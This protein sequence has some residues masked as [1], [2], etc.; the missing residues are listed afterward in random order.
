MPF[1]LYNTK[2]FWRPENHFF[3]IQIIYL[4]LH[5]NTH[6]S[7]NFAAPWT[8]LPGGRQH[9]FLYPSPPLQVTPLLVL[10]ND[11]Q[12]IWQQ[13]EVTSYYMEGTN[14]HGPLLE[15]Y[16]TAEWTR[17][18]LLPHKPHCWHWLHN[19]VYGKP[20]SKEGSAMHHPERTAES[21]VFSVHRV[22]IDEVCRAQ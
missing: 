22:N 11:F 9:R 13:T 1:C 10:P 14:K 20:Q 21:P 8:L 2:I 3:S 18:S 12:Q 6:F 4:F 19:V 5:L 17:K 7:I 15:S 16:C